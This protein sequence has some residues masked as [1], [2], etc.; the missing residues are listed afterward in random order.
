MKLSKTFAKCPILALAIAG[1]AALSH[2]Q[3]S[4]FAPIAR[5]KFQS[6][7]LTE[8]GHWIPEDISVITG[9]RASAD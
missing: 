3:R 2:R 1:Y 9:C 7:H 5:R 8:A 4:K 6:Q